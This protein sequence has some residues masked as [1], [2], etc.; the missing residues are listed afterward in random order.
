MDKTER[1]K[2]PWNVGENDAAGNFIIEDSRSQIVCIVG[3]EDQD[4]AANAHRIVACVNSC[5]GVATEVLEKSVPLLQQDWYIER[6][7]LIA[8]RDR[9]RSLNGELVMAL[10][11]CR[12]E[13]CWHGN[14]GKSLSQSTYG[15]LVD[16]IDTL[17]SQAW[18]SAA[19]N[20]RRNRA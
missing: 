14:T 11:K 13:F 1:S 19:R 16:M 12:E 9:L 8:E 2:G 4:N 7:G 6:G 18:A 3:E 5:E 17:L 10:N 20:M 15:E